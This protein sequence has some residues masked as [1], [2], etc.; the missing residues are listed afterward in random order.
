MAAFSPNSSISMYNPS[1]AGMFQSPGQPNYPSAS[2]SYGLSYS[3]AAASSPLPSTPRNQVP[4]AQQHYGANTGTNIGGQFPLGGQFPQPMVSPRQACPDNQFSQAAPHFGLVNQGIRVSTPMSYQVST[5]NQIPSQTIYQNQAMLD[6]HLSSSVPYQG[7]R[8]THPNPPMPQ[9]HQVNQF[10]PFMP[11]Q[12]QPNPVHQFPATPQVPGYNQ[13]YAYPMNQENQFG[14]MQ[15]QGLRPPVFPVYQQPQ[16]PQMPI[17]AYPSYNQ[18]L[19]PNQY[20]VNIPVQGQGQ[21]APINQEAPII[22]GPQHEVFAQQV[23]D[24]E[25]VEDVIV[26][27]V[28][29]REPLN[30]YPKE[31]RESQ[32]NLKSSGT[33]QNKGTPFQEP[34]GKSNYCFLF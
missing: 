3:L 31:R 15:G 34:E 21:N 19:G 22:Q 24:N 10:Q 32:R 23:K 26:H 27:K 7:Q 28:D 17:H 9:G 30:D 2:A 6:C 1:Q 12:G 11:F 20:P 18:G 13:G 4:Q 14:N 16:F 5:N 25:H 29:K 33:Q 8:Q